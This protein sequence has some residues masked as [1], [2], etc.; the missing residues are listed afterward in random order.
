M[1]LVAVAMVSAV[2]ATGADGPGGYRILAR[3]PAGHGLLCLTQTKYVLL[4]SGTPEQMVAAHGT[5]F[6]QDVQKLMERVIYVVGGAESV[7]SGQWFLDRMEEIQR[8]T[9][10]YIPPR[11]FAE[12]DALSKAAG[13]SVRDGRYGNLFPE[14]FH[15][16]GFAVRAPPPRTAACS[17]RGCSTT[18]GTSSSRM[19]PP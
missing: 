16:S 6:R 12:C 19:P 1:F 9:L 10:P 7:Y 3:D 14:R 8:R 15:C 17:T 13:V 4:V 5:L 18:C 11:F 2:A